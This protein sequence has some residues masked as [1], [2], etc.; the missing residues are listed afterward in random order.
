[1][2]VEE[3][4][5]RK[6][7]QTRLA[8]RWRALRW[9]LTAW[10][11]SVFG[12]GLALMAAGSLVMLSLVLEQRS[13][14]YLRAAWRAFATEL[15][16]EA[17]DFASADSAIAM[18]QDEVNFE[19]TRFVV[20]A[21]AGDARD[22]DVAP[23]APSQANVLLSTRDG[24]AGG[25]RLAVGTVAFHGRDWTVVAEHP[26]AAL[27]ETVAAIALAYA[28]A[29]PLVLGVALAG[30]YG[31]ARRALAPVAA[32]A[33]RARAIEAATLHDRL[34]VDD[35][36]DEIGELAGVINA[37]LARLEVAFQQQ[38]RLVADASHEL[39]TPVAVL[40]AEADVLLAR[41]GRPEAEYRERV[42]VLRSAAL[43]LTRLV[44]DL[45]LL[46]RADSGQI[47]PRCEPLY[48]DELLAD[49]VRTMQ[50][51]AAQ[52]DVSLTLDVASSVTLPFDGHEGTS[53]DA[54]D[55][56][57]PGAWLDGDPSLLDRLVLNLLDNAIK[58]SPRGGRVRVTLD[59][60]STLGPHAEY[61]VR[62]SDEGPGISP[63]AQPFIFDRFFREDAARARV[64]DAR[65][66]R[67][68]NVQDGHV[69]VGAESGAADVG[70]AGLGLAIARWVAEGHRGTLE[71]EHSSARGTTMRLRLPTTSR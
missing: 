57:L 46:T 43:R 41:Q 20:T 19:D 65:L 47:S 33:R 58:Y 29:L 69:R 3:H 8:P 45:F 1:V 26:R 27:R 64:S 9:R 48:L 15:L 38:R 71:L 16:V 35:P 31:M 44:D 55:E 13:D 5:A 7:G 18:T 50:A 60:V 39:R 6:P 63:D 67:P 12:I 51:V 49:A 32:M 66:S 28:F 37:L 68:G 53:P 52:R 21:A 22:A 62:V 10:Y 56:A 61:I 24:P 42:G 54:A 11:A 70:G 25:T 2:T 40:L 17:R 14:R 30:G 36:H 59:C 34:P 23:P 4:S